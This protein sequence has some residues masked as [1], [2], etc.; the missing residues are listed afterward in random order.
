VLAAVPGRISERGVQGEYGKF[1]AIDHGTPAG[2]TDRYVTHYAQLSRFAPWIG[3]G[4]CV[5]SGDVIGFAG[6]TGM[7][8]GPH[9]HYEVLI[10]DKFVDP[11]N[12][13]ITAPQIANT[14]TTESPPAGEVPLPRLRGLFVGI[15]EYMAPAL[16]LRFA[17]KDASD[18]ASFFRSQ[19]GL[20]YS[21]VE[22]KVLANARRAEILEALDWLESG[23]T[24]EDLNLIFLAGHGITDE[25]HTFY[26]M[27]SDSDPKRLRSTGVS[28]DQLLYTIRNL[29]GARVVMLDTCYS[30][31][32]VE[33]V[34]AQS[35]VDMSQFANELGDPTLGV[36]LFVSATCH[37]S[38][39]EDVSWDN[40]MFTR[41]LIEGLSG[42]ADSQ[43]LGYVES[44]ELGVYIHRRVL[45][46]TGGRQEPVRF[47]SDTAPGLRLAIVPNP[48][49]SMRRP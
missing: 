25:K 12:V 3:V 6:S 14:P 11:L 10:N 37:Q 32:T 48:G 38:S 22:T 28:R 18:L 30:G 24:V 46:L 35:R 17:V 33:A 29:R 20:A 31:A 40:G 8:T 49:K 36:F 41:A 34:P 21:S 13:K 44:D 26:F 5:K 47:K 42:A 16:R 9:L 4:A 2:A 39:Y 23:S 43:H 19:Q 27:A 45:A 1:I 15:N 7:A